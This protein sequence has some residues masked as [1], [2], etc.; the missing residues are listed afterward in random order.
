M[1]SEKTSAVQ[2]VEGVAQSQTKTQEKT[3]PASSAA[4]DVTSSAGNVKCAATETTVLQPSSVE[5]DAASLTKALLGM[6]DSCNAA[7]PPVDGDS[8]ENSQNSSQ[9]MTQPLGEGVAT[10]PLLNSRSPS[11]FTLTSIPPALLVFL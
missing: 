6:A 1:S 11:A 7:P 10:Q 8:Q 9:G 2:S 4:S 3:E 5:S